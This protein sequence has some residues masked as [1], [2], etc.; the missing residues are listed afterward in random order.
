M[1]A[2]ASTQCGTC[3]LVAGKL[4]YSASGTRSTCSISAYAEILKARRLCS[5]DASLGT[6][7]VSAVGW[8]VGVAGCSR[9]QNRNPTAEKAQEEEAV[10]WK[11]LVATERYGGLQNRFSQ[12]SSL[13]PRSGN[14]ASTPVRPHWLHHATAPQHSN[15]HIAFQV[16]IHLDHTH[17]R[18]EE[19]VACTYHISNTVLIGPIPAN[20]STCSRDAAHEQP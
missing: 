2:E 1:A 18:A 5:K 11:T 6:Q 3:G 4:T 9:W 12:V 16:L 10:N 19:R 17:S 8:N 7:R 13:F 14:T 15:P 20:P